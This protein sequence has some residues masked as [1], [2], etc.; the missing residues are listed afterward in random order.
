MGTQVDTFC[1]GLTGPLGGR[2]VETTL[3]GW[4]AQCSTQERLVLLV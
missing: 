4:G 3:G 2:G 1:P